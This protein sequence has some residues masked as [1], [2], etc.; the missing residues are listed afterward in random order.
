MELDKKNINAFWT[1]SDNLTP[2]FFIINEAI[3]S[4]LCVLGQDYEPC[5]EGATIEAPKVEFSFDEDFKTRLFSMMNEI[6][7]ILDKGG[8]P[9][10]NEV[11]TPIEDTVIEE[12]VVVEDVIVEEVSEEE[13]V[14]PV[15][16]E[17]VPTAEEEEEE[18]PVTEEEVPV[19]E[20]VAAPAYNLEEVVEYA[21]LNERY[22]AL[23][24]SYNETVANNAAL[25]TEISNLQTQIEEL[26]TF[27][28]TVE[29]N[30]KL[31]LVDKFYMLSDDLKSD[32]V[33]NIDSY[34]LEDIEAKLSIICVRNKVSFDL[35]ENKTQPTVFNIHSGTVT[36]DM[37]PAWIKSAQSVAKKMK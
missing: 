12:E 9:M 18:V 37:I 16:E 5:F 28:K 20:E 7:E 17:E 19:V 6:K 29:K 22:A 11:M 32:V 36:D 25:N 27:K 30:A 34:S 10:E 23:E 8:V 4:K 31:A 21:E 33:N 1:K 2:R 14:A 3:I 15:E 26:T 13:I 35:D 24:A